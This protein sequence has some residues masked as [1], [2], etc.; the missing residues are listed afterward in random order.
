MIVRFPAAAK[1]MTLAL[2]GFPQIVAAQSN[3]IAERQ[4]DTMGLPPA[5]RAEVICEGREASKL[6]QKLLGEPDYRDL[7]LETA[8][9]LTQAEWATAKALVEA[10]GQ[11]DRTNAGLQ[12]MIDRAP[13]L[14]DGR[15]IFRAQDGQYVDENG[16]PVSRG[17]VASAR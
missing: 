11:L 1:A 17:E 8:D 14:P 9:T 7:W 16:N 15:A 4:V 12:Q 10:Q 3:D 6:C 5:E 13:K 2:L